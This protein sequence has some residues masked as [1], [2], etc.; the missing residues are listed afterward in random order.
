M[1]D[2]AKVEA[3]AVKQA[4]N[5][6]K[7]KSK[8]ELPDQVKVITGKDIK[9][10]VHALLSQYVTDGDVDSGKLQQLVAQNTQLQLRLQQAQ[11]REE[12]AK[13]EVGRS[14]DVIDNLQAQLNKAREN[15]VDPEKLRKLEED[16]SYL[17]SENASKINRITELEVELQNRERR[18]AELADFEQE[19]ERLR[20][21]NAEHVQNIE[22]LEAR[23]K[24]RAA[25][26]QQLESLPEKNEAL[27]KRLSEL[28]Q[29]I[30]ERDTRINELLHA[31]KEMLQLR[32]RVA[33]LEQELAEA[34]KRA[35]SVE[36]ESRALAREKRHTG[37]LHLELSTI[38]DR[39]DALERELDASSKA[40]KE[41]DEEIDKLR[42]ELEQRPEGIDPEVHESLKNE[43][44]ILKEAKAAAEAR[45]R[46]LDKHA[47]DVEAEIQRLH[48]KLEHQPAE[49][50]SGEL[51]ALRAQLADL[52]G[53]RDTW[54]DRVNKTED[55]AD[56]AIEAR[57]EAEVKLADVSARLESVRERLDDREDALKRLEE[58]V[59]QPTMLPNLDVLADKLAD[60]HHQS[61]PEVESKL[62][63]E[64]EELKK[65]VKSL[66][67]ELAKAEKKLQE[68]K[69]S[70]GG[71]DAR[72][73]RLKQELENARRDRKEN[74]AYWK[75]EMKELSK[76]LKKALED[77]INNDDHA[78]PLERR[79]E[80][81]NVGAMGKYS[82][83]R[84]KHNKLKKENDELNEEVKNLQ[85]M[86][87]RRGK[88]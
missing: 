17:Q 18:I 27:K 28:E 19:A 68:A 74:E 52:R 7:V 14:R 82:K 33:K 40:L 85:K 67:R 1:S 16:I 29:G 66:E 42:N 55:K 72:V 84:K 53:D 38:K 23:L 50:H 65:E 61:D 49:N 11:K 31:E 2:N 58:Q 76:G 60:A 79:L 51:E 6:T 44:A 80:G 43:N 87:R 22:T 9:D 20:Q 73:D 75:K 56:Q 88:A 63:R 36:E 8:N 46:D 59:A 32:E 62:R 21:L 47:K 48:N 5:K 25:Q 41:R 30:H 81:M 78:S 71:S 15:R 86:L 12:G 13:V 24:Q 4:I 69:R 34:R 45:S 54:R 77:A 70:G 3:D 26:I 39:S 35:D 64:N 57:R 83:L 10:I 37:K